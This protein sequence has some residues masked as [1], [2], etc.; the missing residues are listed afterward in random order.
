MGSIMTCMMSC[1]LLYIILMFVSQGKAY[2]Q[3]LADYQLT[4][5]PEFTSEQLQGR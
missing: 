5:L 1:C 2:G 4:G 3:M